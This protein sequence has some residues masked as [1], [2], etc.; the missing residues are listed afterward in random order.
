M[1]NVKGVTE[2]DQSFDNDL[3]SSIE[4]WTSEYH[5]SS[6]DSDEACKRISR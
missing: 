5:D 2:A 6:S 4:K 3:D 1:V